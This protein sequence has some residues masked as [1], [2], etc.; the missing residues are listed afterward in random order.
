MT[1]LFMSSVKIFIFVKNRFMKKIFFILVSLIAFSDLKAQNDSLISKTETIYD[2]VEV[3]PTYVGGTADM[4]R[5]IAM[6]FRYP[7]KSRK[8]NHQGK[9]TVKITLDENGKISEAIIIK[10]IDEG[11]D[12]ETLRVVKLMPKWN[13]GKIKDKP[14]KCRHT[15]SVTCKLS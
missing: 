4:Y 1:L 6:N 13:P 2:T 11:L 15:F 14:V 5:F 12:A 8:A 9:V 10:G 7:E 3:A